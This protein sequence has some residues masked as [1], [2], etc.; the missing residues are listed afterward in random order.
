MSLHNR[1]GSI[2]GQ[3]LRNSWHDKA[4][5]DIELIDSA[6]LWLNE[7]EIQSEEAQA[8]RETCVKVV[9]AVKKKL[10]EGITTPFSNYWLLNH[11]ENIEPF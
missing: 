10:A 7:A 11:P 1:Y 6:L 2:D 9:R 5:L 3:H 4:Q 8:L